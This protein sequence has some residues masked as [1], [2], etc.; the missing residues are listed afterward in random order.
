MISFLLIK[1][2][3]IFQKL[4]K[5]QKNYSQNFDTVG[6]VLTCYSA[7]CT[8]ME[9]CRHQR[10]LSDVKTQIS[11]GQIYRLRNVVVASSGSGD[12][13][14]LE[15]PMQLS[16]IHGTP[17]LNGLIMLSSPVRPKRRKRGINCC[18]WTTILSQFAKRPSYERNLHWCSLLI[19]PL[20]LSGRGPCIQKSQTV[21]LYRTAL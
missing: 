14:S 6:L 15:V 16:D 11:S 4:T 5:E 20:N 3:T 9:L 7:L 13:V 2:Y 21:R 12:P 1:L 18:V 8:S 10:Y 19:I 17:L